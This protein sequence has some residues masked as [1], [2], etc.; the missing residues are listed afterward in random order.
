VWNYGVQTAYVPI[1]TLLPPVMLLITLTATLQVVLL[2]GEFPIQ[3]TFAMFD[4][5]P[6]AVQAPP[7]LRRTV[8]EGQFTSQLITVPAGIVSRSGAAYSELCS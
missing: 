8:P 4:A 1:D 3:L 6:V 7:P 5:P 2:A